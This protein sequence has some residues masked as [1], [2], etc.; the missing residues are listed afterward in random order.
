VKTLLLDLTNWDLC[1]DSTGNI[2]VASEPY[3]IAQSVASACRTFLGDLWYNQTA[4]IPYF[5]QILGYLPPPALIKAWLT[6]QALTVPGCANPV[7]YLTYVSARS[8]SGQVQF[9][10]ATGATQTATFG[11]GAATIIPPLVPSDYLGN[12]GGGYVG[13]PFGGWV[14]TP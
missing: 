12:P 13:D 4:G 9:T 1:T 5:G 11:A 14:G 10:D 8:V 3:S 2:A 6:Q 7:V